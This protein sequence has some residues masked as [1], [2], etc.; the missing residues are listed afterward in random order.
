[1]INAQ[2]A[3]LATRPSVRARDSVSAN[4]GSAGQ[5]NAAPNTPLASSATATSQRVGPVE[6]ADQGDARGEHDR[7]CY[8]RAARH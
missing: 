2:M 5:R 7:D 6:R 8:S 4:Q 3:R 1:M